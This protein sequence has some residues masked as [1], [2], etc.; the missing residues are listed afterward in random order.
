MLICVFIGFSS[1]LPLYL[2]INL[3]PAWLRTEGVDL[4]AI[5]LFAL[6]QLP[7]TWK[8]LWSPLLDRSRCP[9]SAPARLDAR[10]AGAAARRHPAFGCCI[11]SST[12]GRSPTCDRGRV[13]LRE[14]GHRA[15][16]VSPRNPARC[17]AGPR[18]FGLRQRVPDLEPRSGF[19]GAD[20][21]RPDAVVVGVPHH[22]AVH[23][24]RHRDDADGARAAALVKA[25]RGRC[26]KRWSCR[27]TNSS[28]ARAGSTRCWCSR[29]SFSTSW[30]TAWP[31]RSPRRSTS[32]WASRG[33]TSA[34]SPRMRGCGRASSA[35]CW[36]GCGW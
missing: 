20:P 30:A 8:F 3:L 14:P 36:A 26:A 31:R 7:Y 1:G 10:H 6:I 25:R 27:S 29:S 28:R 15:R 13:L 34:S 21:R 11:R 5:G 17:R 35:A 2:L 24:A 33:P 18:Q 4:K 23:A 9:G 12:S 16:R 32:T 22:G 19:A